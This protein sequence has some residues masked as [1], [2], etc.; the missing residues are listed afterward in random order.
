M[1]FFEGCRIFD[2]PFITNGKVFAI[3]ELW[4]YIDWDDE[5]YRE[6]ISNYCINFFSSQNY[7]DDILCVTDL[8]FFDMIKYCKK[9]TIFYAK[10]ANFRDDSNTRFYELNTYYETIKQ[11]IFIGYNVYSHEG[12]AF[13]DGLY[14]AYLD[15]GTNGNLCYNKTLEFTL[16]R[17][18]LLDDLID[19][20]EIC[21]INNESLDNCDYN[22]WYPN[23][24]YVDKYTYSV[25]L[26]YEEP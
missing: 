16:N 18:G 13:T 26:N 12:S 3:P 4:K 22:T 14:P 7:P 24:L 19:C 10:P 8:R 21:R 25:I 23:A 5:C 9:L 20:E 15:R 11:L 17:F 6:Y 1:F 2:S